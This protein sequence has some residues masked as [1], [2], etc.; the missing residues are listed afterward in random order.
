MKK[1]LHDWLSLMRPGDWVCLFGGCCFVGVSLAW[2]SHSGQADKAIIRAGGALFAEVPLTREARIVVPGPLGE[3]VIE[4]TQGRARVLSDP[5][6]RQ[7]CVQ[8]GW[9]VRAGAI[10]LCAPNQVSLALSGRHPGYDSL[11]Y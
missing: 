11:G 7:Y 2:L 3:T 9:L 5:S 10:A 6:P 1:P 4:I 8:Q